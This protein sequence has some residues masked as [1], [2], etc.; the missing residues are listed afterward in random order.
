MDN[1]N[2]ID[3]RL[4]NPIDDPIWR[5][6]HLA[7]ITW[8]LRFRQAP[9]R[10]WEISN[11]CR[12]AGKAINEPS[13]VFGR[14]AGDVFVNLFK[15]PNGTLGPL[16][17]HARPNCRRTSATSTTSSRSL[18]AIPSSTSSLTWTRYIKSSHV[19]SSGRLATSCAASSLTFTTRFYF[20]FLSIHSRIRSSSTFIGRAPAPRTSSWN[21]RMSKRGP[22]S[23]RACSRRRVMVNWPI[24]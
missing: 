1:R 20:F 6:D 15:V 8:H 9:A 10:E 11:L 12:A 14:V 5:L 23:W 16:D 17:C 19:A 3:T 7:E 2:D 18:S 21:S 4:S 24:L 22:S 13:R